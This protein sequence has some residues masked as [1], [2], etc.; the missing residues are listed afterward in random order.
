MKTPLCQTQLDSSGVRDDLYWIHDHEVK[1][2]G[3]IEPYVEIFLWLK[4]EQC[5]AVVLN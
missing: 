3:H 2:Q 5:N 1:G 4:H